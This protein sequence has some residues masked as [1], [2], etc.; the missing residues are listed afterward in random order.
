MERLLLSEIAACLGAGCPKEC[1]IT[2]ISTDTRTIT[3][4]SLFVAIKGDNFDGNEFVKKAIDQGA[5]A[6]VCERETEGCPCIVVED[7]RKAFLDIA[8][9]YRKKFS[10]VLVGVTG[11][12]GKTTTKEM[13]ALVLSEKYKTLKTQGNLNNGIGLPK[14]LLRLDSSYEAAVI[15]MGMNHFGEIS[16]LTKTALP[17]MAVITNIGYSHIENLGSREGILK[18]KLEILEGMGKDSPLITNGDNDL[19]APLK[20]KLDCPV[21]LYGI[22]NDKCDVR[23]ENIREENG[24]TFFTIR[25]DGSVY[26]MMIPCIGVHNVMNAL[27]AFAVGVKSGLTPSEIASALKKYQPEGMRQRIENRN[28]TDIIIDCYNASPDSMKASLSV[29]SGM[30]VSGRRAAV[31]GDMLELGERSEE[32]HRLVGKYVC[33]YKPDM[34]YCYGKEAGY[35]ADEAEKGGIKAYAFGKDE[36]EGLSDAL[37]KELKSEDAVLFKASRGM[38]LEEVIEKVFG[39]MIGGK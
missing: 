34:L 4:G 8:R 32:L 31:L 39:K 12:V 37:S 25:Y 1:E 9:L 10:P 33:E 30:K 27:C 23:A 11:S 21:L 26:D 2:E 17:T 28:G 18:A 20:E 24:E 3:Q 13:T 36:K 38:K 15:E 6:T 14:T 5:S 16:S 29:L 19:L 7:T 35:I 22:E